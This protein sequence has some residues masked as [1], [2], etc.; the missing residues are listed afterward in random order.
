MLKHW[1][2]GF[3]FLTLSLSFSSFS[4]ARVT[5]NLLSAL[6]SGNLDEVIRLVEEGADINAKSKDGATPLHLAAHK[7]RR[8]VAKMLIDK[9]ADLNAKN[10]D[11]LTP[12]AYAIRVR[13]RA[14]AEVIWRH[15]G[16]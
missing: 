7:R 6:E 10:K 14:V 5:E 4:R 12:L 8:D 15:G 11:G 9:G 1:M 3:I 16:K 13:N 2:V